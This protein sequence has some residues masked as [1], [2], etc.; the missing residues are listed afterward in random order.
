MRKSSLT[1]CLQTAHWSWGGLAEAASAL[2]FTAEQLDDVREASFSVFGY[3]TPASWQRLPRRSRWPSR[4][5]ERCRHRV[6]VASSP[7]KG[8]VAVYFNFHDAELALIE[9]VNRC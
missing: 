7:T 6:V 9:I 1:P 5:P 8:I 3:A 4:R 2:F